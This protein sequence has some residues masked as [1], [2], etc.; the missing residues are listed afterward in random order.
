MSNTAVKLPDAR[1]LN[2]RDIVPKNEFQDCTALL[3]DHDALNEFYEENGYL[4]FRKALSPE[5]VVRARDE[6]L[7]IAAD[8]YGLVEKGDPTARWTGKPIEGFSEDGDEFS[9]ISRRLIEDPSNQDFL[10]KVLGEPAA[11][12]PLVQYRLY[13]PDG[14]ITPVHQDG[15]YSPGIEGYRPV[16]TALVDC[17]R[18]VGGLMVAVGQHKKGFFHNLA[19]SD[20]SVP[21]GLIDPESWTTT[22]F[23][24]GDVLVVHP[25]SPHAGTPNTS[26]RLRV[27]FDTR[28]QSARNPKAFAAVVKAVTPTSLTVMADQENVGE[29]TLSVSEDTF[30][31]VRSPGV[32]EDFSR[33]VEYTVPGMRLLVVREGDHAQMLR[34]PTAP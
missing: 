31:R 4:F 7:A 25:Y 30:I 28:V 11:M 9:G 32:R 1:N 19:K 34:C 13:P 14:P 29:V 33:F 6:M 17:P 22:D 10:A 16:W 5:S 21:E 27:T 26:D 15:F 18:D 3:D 2:A 23:T 24:A 8:T 12:V 20:F